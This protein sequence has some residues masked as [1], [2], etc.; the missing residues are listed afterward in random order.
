MAKKRRNR[1]FL[2]LLPTAIVGLIA[3]GAKVMAD[4]KKG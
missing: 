1:H 3:F 2:L 4:R